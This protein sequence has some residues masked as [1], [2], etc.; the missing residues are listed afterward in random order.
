MSLICPFNI[1]E[2]TYRAFCAV[3]RKLD[4]SYTDVTLPYSQVTNSNVSQL[5]MHTL[6]ASAS[7]SKANAGTEIAKTSTR[8]MNREIA[9]FIAILLSRFADYFPPWLQSTYGVRE[10]TLR[11]TTLRPKGDHWA[12]YTN[13]GQAFL[14]QNPKNGRTNQAELQQPDLCVQIESIDL[15]YS[16]IETCRQNDY[17]DTRCT[18]SEHG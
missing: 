12:A 11:T 16:A 6:E 3:I 2:N 18:S 10:K 17:I 1:D 7:S 15:S 5:W 13:A 8:I 14:L 4:N 9:F